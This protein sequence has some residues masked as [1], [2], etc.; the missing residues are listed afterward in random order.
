[1][2]QRSFR[3]GIHALLLSICVGEPGVAWASNG[4]NL[5]GFGAGSY[6]MGGGTRFRPRRSPAHGP[7]A[8]RCSVHHAPRL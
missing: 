6:I 4:L 7:G 5:I 8:G 3:L 1:M 2:H